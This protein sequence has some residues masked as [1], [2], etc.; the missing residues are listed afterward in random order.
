M[1]N[2]D[3]NYFH[4]EP[5]TSERISRFDLKTIEKCY[6]IGTKGN[7]NIVATGRATRQN[8]MTILG[9]LIA[10][11]TSLIGAFFY[12]F[13]TGIEYLSLI[14]ITGYGIVATGLI[15]WRLIKGSLYKVY[16]Y[17]SGDMPSILIRDENMRSLDKIPDEEYEEGEK[18]TY[19]LGWYLENIQIKYRQNESV[20]KR[21]VRT[22]R[23]TIISIATALAIAV[24][25]FVALSVFGL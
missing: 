1:E 15:I 6:E 13:L 21:I 2:Q 23:S 7:D 9:W 12:Q 5:I 24:V 25:L 4:G 3:K 8:C 17:N 22:Y 19:V 11:F 20:C 18:Y 16:I 14:I 10:A